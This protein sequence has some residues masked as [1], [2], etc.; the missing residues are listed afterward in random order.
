[1]SDGEANVQCPQQPG[2]DAK[3]DAIQAACDAARQGIKV[4]AVAFGSNADITTLESIASCGEGGFYFGNLED[5]ISIYEDIAQEILN[6]AY[7]EQT[8]IGEGFHTSLFPSSYISLEYEKEIPYG[9]V[10]SAESENFGSSAPI[11]TFTI[12][13]NTIPYEAKVV[14]YSG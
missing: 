8:V 6:A 1:M 5:L 13:N 9:L 7:Y 2:S 10:V 3:Q 12:P 14:S 4:Y 11:G